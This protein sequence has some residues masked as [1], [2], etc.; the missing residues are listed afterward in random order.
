MNNMA[1]AD[2]IKNRFWRSMMDSAAT[3]GA[4][5]LGAAAPCNLERA[6]L[7]AFRL[8]SPTRAHVLHVGGDDGDIHPHMM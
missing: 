7:R 3:L 1:T 4:A 5:A 6:R 8:T 2:F